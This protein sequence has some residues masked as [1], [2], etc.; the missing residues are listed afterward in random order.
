MTDLDKRKRMAEFGG[1]RSIVPVAEEPADELFGEAHGTYGY[2]RLPHFESDPA[3]ACSLLPKLG[4]HALRS[5]RT[6]DIEWDFLLA[7]LATKLALEEGQAV[8]DL[9]Y[10]AICELEEK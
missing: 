2:Q 9:I 1:W 4:P 7:Q 8:C 3:A 10:N 6:I 5:D